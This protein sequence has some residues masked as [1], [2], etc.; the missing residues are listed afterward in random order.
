[1]SPYPYVI[2]YRLDGEDVVVTR[3]RHTSRRPEQ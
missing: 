3:F 1:M 2:F